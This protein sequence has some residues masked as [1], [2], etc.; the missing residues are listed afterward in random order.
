MQGRRRETEQVVT[1]VTE[2]N[3]TAAEVASSAANAATATS[4][5]SH[6]AADAKV[7]A[8]AAATRSINDLVGEVDQASQV[9]GQLE[10]E[11]S[12]IGSVVEVIRGIAEQTNLLALNL[13]IEAARAEQGRGFAVVA[14]EV[15]SLAGRTQQSTLE[16]NSMLQ[17]LQAGVARRCKSWI[18]ARSA[19]SR[20]YRRLARSPTRSMEWLP[21]LIPSTR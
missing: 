13:T 14:D 15:R 6:E 1:A 20:R 16:I 7:W 17:R 12:K 9:I 21:R 19:V 10:Q 4:A 11:T 2:M 5:A 8:V 18:P 3:S